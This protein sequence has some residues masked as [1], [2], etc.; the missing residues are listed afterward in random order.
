M[1]IT[2]ID[3]MMGSGKTTWS[4]DFMK[5][6]MSKEKILFVTPFLDEITRIKEFAKSPFVAIRNF[7]EPVNCGKG[8]KH[9]FEELLKD[10]RNIALTHELFKTISENCCG[11]IKKY[12]YTLVLD[13]VFNPIDVYKGYSAF[14]VE[15][16]IKAEYVFRDFDERLRLTDDRKKLREIKTSTAYKPLIDDI[17]NGRVLFTEK[18]KYLLWAFPHHVFGLFREVY[19]LTFLFEKEMMGS[20]FKAF[21][22]PYEKKSVKCIDGVYTLVDYYEPDLSE[23][24]KLITFVRHGRKMFKQNDWDMT[25][26]W[27]KSPQNKAKIDI[28]KNGIYQFFITEGQATGADDR[29]WTTFKKSAKYK[30]RGKGYTKAFTFLNNKATNAF[31]DRHYLVHAAN[32]YPNPLIYNFLHRKGAVADKMDYVLPDLL[33]WVWRSALR[34]KEPIHLYIVSD[35]MAKAFYEFV[36][37]EELDMALRY[38]PHVSYKQYLKECKKEKE[39]MIELS[40]EEMFELE[41]ADE[42]EFDESDD[43]EEDD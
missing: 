23:Y 38:Y 4:I 30:L 26:K 1:K 12:G 24:A 16:L 42:D 28:I 41:Y 13:E 9:S 18:E 17:E 5:E 20:Y 19:I 35:R 27:F 7:V 10:G 3:S 22:I 14:D 40:E 15:L 8:K 31:G 29:L 34:N 25:V 39:N 37:G 36:F 33:Q 21:E 6:K 2:V 11:S 43:S 32:V